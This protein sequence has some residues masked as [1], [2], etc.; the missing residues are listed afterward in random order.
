MKN[1]ILAL[2]CLAL[3]CFGLLA[4]LPVRAATPLDTEAD[5]ALTLTYQKDGTPFRELPVK[6]YRIARANADGTFSLVS[7]YSS[8][9]IH[10][11]DI[12]DQAQWKTVADT[13]H[14]YII[15]RQVAPDREGVTDENGVAAFTDL[16]PGLYFVSEVLAEEESGTHRFDRFLVYVPTPQPDGT[17]DYQVEARPKPVDFIPNPQYTV[18]KLWKDSGKNRPTEISVEIYK[19]GVLQETVTLNAANNWTYSWYAKSDDPG[20]WTV[21]EPNVPAGYR[22]T[23]QENGAHFTLINSKQSTPDNPQTGDS[24]SPLPWILALCLSG[25]LLLILALYY[26]RRK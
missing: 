18:T 3:L 11:H 14:S 7:P 12:S 16:E 2:L 25:I 8:F 15:A 22:L 19:D 5:C 13:L 26:R 9:P 4:P 10:I 24:F 21:A 23:V 6:L 17:F 20:L 1:R